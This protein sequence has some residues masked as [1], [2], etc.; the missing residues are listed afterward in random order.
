MDSGTGGGDIDE[1]APTTVWVDVEAGIGDGA[2]SAMAF[3][4]ASGCDSKCRR[5][6]DFWLKLRLHMSQR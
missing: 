1:S 3:S 2:A 4:G 5:K 6:P